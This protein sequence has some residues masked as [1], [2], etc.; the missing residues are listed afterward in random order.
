MAKPLP[1]TRRALRESWRGL[2]GWMAGILATLGLYLPLYPS[3]AGPE[4][5]SLIE[6]L[7]DAL[8]QALGYDQI[9]SGAGYTQATFFGLLGFALLSIAAISWGA[10]AGGGH[11][12]SGRLELDLA[13][14]VSRRGFVGQAFLTLTIKLF[15]LGIFAGG[16][17]AALNTPSQLD[18]SLV[19]LTWA[20]VGLVLLALATGTIALAGGLISGRRAGGVAAGAT[21]TIGGYVLNAVGNLVENLSW[22]SSLSP[23]TWAFGHQPLINGA[24]PVGVTLLAGLAVIGVVVS[25]VALNR[26]DVLG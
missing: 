9:T 7:P 19:N 22:V 1:L 12:E 13:H 3:I 14:R 20:V 21:I 11:E 5:L 25:L 23:Y 8:I 18:L 4:M 10:G 15:A 17:T 26:R 6:S 16:V 2:L 24:D